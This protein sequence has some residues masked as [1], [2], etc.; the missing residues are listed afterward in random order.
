MAR[1]K[2]CKREM[3]WKRLGSGRW[4]PVEKDGSAHWMRCRP[5]GRVI[6]G[7][8][9]T[10]GEFVESGCDC[11]VPPWEACRHSSP[12]YLEIDGAEHVR[13]ILCETL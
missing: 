2:R 12:E 10:G 1:C 9:I 8:T 11:D 3:W 13:A 4:M 7:K 5:V 6:E